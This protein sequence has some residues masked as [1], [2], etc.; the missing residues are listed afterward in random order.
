MGSL[1]IRYQADRSRRNP[2]IIL[3]D[4][5]DSNGNTPFDYVASL[6]A[7]AAPT[8]TVTSGVSGS[9][10]TVASGSSGASSTAGSAGTAQVSSSKL[11][12]AGRSVSAGTEV[13]LGGLA[14]F[15]GTIGG[16]MLVRA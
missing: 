3:T 13:W 1:L 9:T 12:G 8:S 2:N 6:N 14:L 7:I 15:V 11:G 16:G 4:F 5:Y 10:A